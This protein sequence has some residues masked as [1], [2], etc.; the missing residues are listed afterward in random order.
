[1]A[2]GRTDKFSTLVGEHVG[3]GLC[4]LAAQRLAGKNDQTA[5]DAVGMTVRLLVCLIDNL[6]EP[7]IVDALFAR[8]GCQRN[9]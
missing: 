7:P 5:I 1:M 3:D 8:I 9:G 6:A 2:G 4:I